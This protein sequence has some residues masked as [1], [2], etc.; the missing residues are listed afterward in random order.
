MPG[1]DLSRDLA[2]IVK[3][4]VDGM[5]SVRPRRVNAVSWLNVPNGS[6]TGNTLVWRRVSFAPVI[7]SRIR[8]NMNATPNY[9]VALTEV[10]AWTAATGP[11]T[12]GTVTFTGTGTCTIRAA[13]SGNANYLGAANVDRSF[14]VSGPDAQL[15]F[16]QQPTNANAGAILSPALAVSILDAAGNPAPSTAN[17][18][19]AL[20]SNPGN[21]PLSGPLTVAAVISAA[22]RSNAASNG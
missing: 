4:I 20:A 21:A 10:E 19:L 14:I 13:Q 12:A 3:W 17:V 22:M 16:V 7:T 9:Y 5:M 11:G 15:A 1:R 8:V 2:G 18:T 6:I